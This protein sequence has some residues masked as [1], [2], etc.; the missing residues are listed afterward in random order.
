MKSKEQIERMVE[1]I[2]NEMSEIHE[3]RMELLSENGGIDTEQN[4]DM[5]SDIV[6]LSNQIKVLE[7][8]LS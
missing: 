7:W 1:S 4:I 6:T 5:I 8:V 2:K 3:Q